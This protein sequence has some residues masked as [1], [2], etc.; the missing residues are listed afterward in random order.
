MDLHTTTRRHEFLGALLLSTSVPVDGLLQTKTGAAPDIVAVDGAMKVAVIN[1]DAAQH[2]CVSYGDVYPFRIQDVKQIRITAKADEF[3]AGV[4]AF[5][6]LGHARNDAKNSV[7]P[8]ILWAIDADNVVTVESA[9]GVGARVV[10]TTGITLE[11]G[12]RQF[13][14]DLSSGVRLGDPRLGGSKGGRAVIQPAVTGDQGTLVPVGQTGTGLLDL[15][16]TTSRM[17][18]LIQIGKASGTGTGAL[19]IRDIEIDLKRVVAS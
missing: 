3:G 17:Q 19:Y 14:L 4:T 8:A 10:K 5:F 18:L 12:Y 1:T 6:G 16:L 2:N 7:A 9:D 15:S 13:V 11:D